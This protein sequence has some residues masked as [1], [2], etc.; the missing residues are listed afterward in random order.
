MQLAF[1]N[2]PFVPNAAQ[3]I[4]VESAYN[5]KLNKFIRENYEWLQAEFSRKGLS[6]C[7]FPLLAEEVMRYNAPH[8]SNDRLKERA[9]S[10]PSLTQFAITKDPIPP[11]LFFA[12]HKPEISCAGNF[13]LRYVEIKTSWYK[14]LR[15]TFLDLIEQ[16][17]VVKRQQFL[18]YENI[19]RERER[20]ERLVKEEELRILRVTE[21]DDDSGIRFS[22]APGPRKDDETSNLVSEHCEEE[23]PHIRF[24]VAPALDTQDDECCEENEIRLNSIQPPKELSF[25]DDRAF[26]ASNSGIR[27][28]YAPKPDPDKADKDFEHE[29]QKL[30]SEIKA[31]I[32]KLQA[33]G[34]N[35]LFLRELIDERPQLSR[36]RITKDFKIILVDYNALEIQMSLLPKAVFILFLR[37]PEGIRFKELFDYT[38]ELYKIYKA[39]NPNGNEVTHKQSILDVTDSTKNSINEKCARIREAFMKHFDEHLAKYYF[40]TG[41]RGEPKSIKLDR[42]LVIWD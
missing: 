12:I 10:I 11:S 23:Q 41:Q 9:E 42:S 34:V 18:Y 29:S 21:E 39:L 19:R 3:V 40:V 17:L 4:Y 30:I 38:D 36:V 2:L 20:Q 1:K 32:K 25:L 13:I 5:K 31:K 28:S 15:R 14:S 6:F 16:I 37:H 7:Y 33:M 22:C 35:T 27:F 24:S 26:S 8:I